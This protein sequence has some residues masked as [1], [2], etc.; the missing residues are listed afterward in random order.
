MAKTEQ[1]PAVAFLLL[2]FFYP[3]SGLALPRSDFP[4]KVRVFSRYS[5][6]DLELSGE[7]LSVRAESV[8]ASNLPSVSLIVSGREVRIVQPDLG[9]FHRVC[10][11]S[12]GSPM[13]VATT[14]VTARRFL[15]RLCVE[16]REGHLWSVLD[17]SREIYVRGVLDGEMPGDFP[18]EAQKAQAVLIRSYARAQRG[19]HAGEGY[20]F[21]DLTHCQVYG[22]L[23][24]ESG[25]RDEAVRATRSL[26]LT[27]GGKPVEALFHSTC[28]GHTSANQ[29]VFGGRP[30]PY[31]QGVDDGEYCKASPHSE[32]SANLPLNKISATL[33]AD[34]NYA[35]VAPLSGF[36]PLER[37][38]KGRIFSLRLDGPSRKTIATMDFLSLMGK[39]FGWNR[40]KSNWFEVEVKEGA[41]EFHG[42]GLG[43]GVGLCQWGARGM[44]EAGKRFDEILRHYFPGTK[45]ERR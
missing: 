45:L 41:A 9:N 26:V 28:G 24:G 20:D 2:L 1:G 25:L 38:P 14:G 42:R 30:L 43:H 19:R 36:Q 16:V 32:W 37:E 35:S 18:I 27:Y 23:G 15:G 5:P 10:I 6:S 7:R 21:C 29:E 17:V 22:G 12:S 8:A 33:A 44:A 3:I 4:V 39:A 31:L 40:L 13:S 34:E 11:D